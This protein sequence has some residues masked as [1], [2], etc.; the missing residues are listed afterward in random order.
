VQ[1]DS[2]A[3]VGLKPDLRT[4]QENSMNTQVTGNKMHPV[5]WIA[6]IAVILLS[7]AGIGAIFGVIPTAGSSSKQGEPV[8]AA[9]PAQAPAAVPATAPKAA[10][11]AAPAPKPAPKPKVVAKAPEAA[12]APVV[13]QTAP[14]P[15]PAIC[16]NCGTVEDIRQIEQKGEGTGIGAV[17]GGVAGAVV[18]S[19]IGKGGGK[20]AATVLGTVGG[21]VA[22]HQ[23]EKYVRRTVK[24][25]VV[26]RLEDGATRVFTYD[27][28]PS[29]RIGDRVKIDNGVL[30]TR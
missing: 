1:A 20:T 12:P 17:A 15:A 23:V 6:A 16:V 27:T 22:G 25:E 29:W 9:V 13:A 18:G 4:K 2:A 11:Q 14:P 3:E 10:E 24:H 7:A 21:A 28:Q 8:A 19:Q 30:V 5:L 26:V